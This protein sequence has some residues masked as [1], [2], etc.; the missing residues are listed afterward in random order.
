MSTGAGPRARTRGA[1]R[2]RAA[3]LAGCLV[4]FGLVAG[5]IQSMTHA[6]PSDFTLAVAVG[7]SPRQNVALVLVR[8]G[9]GRIVNRY[10]VGGIRSLAWR[11]GRSELA[12]VTAGSKT[13]NAVLLLNPANGR[14]RV[15]AGARRKAPAAFFGV[16]AWAPAGTLIAVTR[17]AGAYGARLEL[18]NGQSGKLVR[19][20]PASARLDSRLSWSS[21]GKAI[22]FTR[23]QRQRGPSSL[24][25][26]DVATGGTRSVAGAS[27]N[28][29]AI[30]RQK[31]VLFSARDGI[32]FIS[33]GRD[34]FMSGSKPGDRSP[35]WSPDQTTVVFE[36]P[37]GG[38]PRSFTR[39]ACAHIFVGLTGALP[40]QL[41]R[42]HARTPAVR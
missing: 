1:G 5:S 38:C 26:L 42:V 16:A 19:S 25:R 18:L 20:F 11:P 33:A 22:F 36:R 2:R 15:L 29:P 39:N 6:G 24:R 23:Q 34:T 28:D 37:L 8:G 13:S 31:V 41:L 21:D 10:P 32:H 12:V 3:I 4:G 9:V 40:T 35:V 7:T 17:S 27:G 14:R 30:N